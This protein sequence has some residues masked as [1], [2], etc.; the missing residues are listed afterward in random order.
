MRGILLP[1]GQR[2]LVCYFNDI[3]DRVQ[4]ERAV[5]ESEERMR[6]ATEATA[7]GIWQ[8]NVITNQIRWDSQ[9]FR[10]Y[11]IQPTADGCV[12][13]SVWCESVVPEDLPHQLE[14]LRETVRVAGK[15]RREFRIRRRD[16]WAIRDVQSV[17]TVRVNVEG[18]TEWVVGTNLDVTDAKAAQLLLRVR[19]R[20]LRSLADN[21]PDMLTRL[22]R[23][24]RHL[25]VNT[26]V[27]QATG[28]AVSE[29]V[30]KSHRQLGMPAQLCDLWESAIQSVFE[31]GQETLIDFTYA[32]VAGARQYSTR[33]VPEFDARGAM[34]SV[35][36]VTTDITDRMHLEQSL[37]AG[38]RRKDEFLATLAHELRNPLAPIQNAV[39]ILKLSQ[40][41]QPA[42]N[43]PIEIMDRQVKQMVRLIDDL[44][45][46][47]R[48]TNGKVFLRRER[49]SLGLIL[50]AAVEATATLMRQ[51]RHE[52]VVVPI[53]ET[54]DLDGDPTRL[55]QIF[56]NLLTN[57]AKYTEPSG[58]ITVTS[59][60]DG[61]DVVVSVSDSGVGIPSHMMRQ[62]FEMF[63]QVDRTLEKTTGGL[64][65][66]L[67]LVKG[68]VEMHGGL[69]EARSDGQGKGSE[70]LVRLPVLTEIVT[71]AVPLEGD[72]Q[73]AITSF[74]VMV[75][76]DNHDAA[77]SMAT[78]LR[79]LGNDTLTA[80]DG[81]EA[82]LACETFQ[83]DVVLLD[84]AMP[85]MNGYEA[86]RQMRLQPGGR[87]IVIIALTGWGTDDDRRRTREFGFNHHLTKPV[88]LT[89]LRTILG[90]LKPRE[91]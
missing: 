33:F 38:D 7:V 44:L 49:V 53:A 81:E 35:L 79:L 56:S 66:G 60:R 32:G 78:M 69:I 90:S 28:F 6:L 27:E 19:E 1:D 2:G 51:R 21:T 68:L 76:D 50:D 22:D 85:T 64:G 18:E 42:V 17:E 74:R 86:C 4:A 63:S 58:K 65:I 29:M 75:V 52:L 83:P 40:V 26:A 62:I 73:P 12:P 20:E 16:D 70:F 39:E 91:R 25:F 23:E 14:T 3:T 57:A 34:E 5:R 80:R 55:V 88:N 84:I 24:Y 71:P 59:V 46:V 36:G 30:G 15:S 11:R 9:M 72:D 47:S 41:G 67:A 54:I 89:S 48:I 82:V 87:E 45:D 77:D 10:I 31:K 43:M 8:W 61:A 37:R 13:F